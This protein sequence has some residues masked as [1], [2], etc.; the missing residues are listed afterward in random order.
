MKKMGIYPVI[1][2]NYLKLNDIYILNNLFKLINL[3]I[4]K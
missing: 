3:K 4:N 2:N 1:K